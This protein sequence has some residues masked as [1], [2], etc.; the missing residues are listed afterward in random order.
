MR[1]KQKSRYKFYVSLAICLLFVGWQLWHSD[2]VQMRFVYLW[3]YQE[4]IIEYANRNQLDPFLVAAVIKNES[5]F[6]KGAKSKP[7][8]VGLMQIMPETGEWIAK[9]MGIGDFVLGDLENSDTNIR[10]GCWYLSELEYEFG[11]NR[12]LILSAYNAGRGNTKNWMKEKGWDD[13]FNDIDAIPFADTREYV[14]S[15]LYDRAQY[16]KLY[17]NRLPKY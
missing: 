6:K 11:R 13:S 9:E 16:Y 15:V 1:K 8:A 17:K 4:E 14:R 5:D 2:E 3:P 7:G 10:M 12:V